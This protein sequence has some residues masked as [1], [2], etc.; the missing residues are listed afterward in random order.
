MKQFKEL[1]PRGLHFSGHGLLNAD[2]V[3]QYEQWKAL[4]D[5]NLFDGKQI[6]TSSEKMLAYIKGKGDALVLE[7][8]DC[9]AEYL[10]AEDLQKALKRA[11]RGDNKNYELDF[12]FIASCYSEITS[13][14]F[15]KVAKH[16]IC[17]D[18]E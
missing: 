6:F 7:K 1:K 2:I 14:I 3:K 12:V 9:T 8:D 15:S 16:V 4:G 11:R 10:Y 13:E 5:Y 17:I 18:K